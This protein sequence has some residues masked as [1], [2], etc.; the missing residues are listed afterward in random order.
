MVKGDGRPE[1]ITVARCLWLQV[2][3][4]AKG[5]LLLFRAEHLD[6]GEAEAIALAH[7]LNADMILMDEK[8]GR[9]AAVRSGLTVLGTLGLLLRA[10]QLG[11]LT[12]IRPEL[13][14]LIKFGF[15]LAQDLYTQVLRAGGELP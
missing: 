1:A 9:R 12:E 3:E 10:K 6:P 14:R 11:I 7:E 15:Y 5:P 2:K 13:D 4:P 8:A